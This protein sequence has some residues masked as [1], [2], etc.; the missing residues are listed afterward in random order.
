MD[1]RE[2]LTPSNGDAIIKR[3]LFSEWRRKNWKKGRGDASGSISW[4]DQ[5][6]KVSDPTWPVRAAQFL[7]PPAL[8]GDTYYRY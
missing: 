1:N 4:A 5:I 8:P 3:H 7:K 6:D 2:T